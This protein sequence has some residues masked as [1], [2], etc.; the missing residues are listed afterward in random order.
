MHIGAVDHRIG[1]A[2]A[3]AKRL[4]GRDAADQCL[5]ERIVHHHLVGVDGAPA[6][7]FANAQRVE[8]REAVRAELDA[9]ADLAQLWCLLQHF[10]GESLARER[11]RRGKA[12]DPA[13]GNED[14]NVSRYTIHCGLLL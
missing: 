12:A 11:E 3:L 9:G 4:A 6:G 1:I 10:D 8:G 5:V 2:E 13:A 14:R 7:L